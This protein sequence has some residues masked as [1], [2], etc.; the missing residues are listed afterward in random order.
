VDKRC[1]V[2]RT[3]IGLLLL[4]PVFAAD[5]AKPW[6]QQP[7][8]EAGYGLAHGLGAGD[9]NG[10]GRVDILNPYGWWEQPAPPSDAIREVTFATPTRR[11]ASSMVREL[12]GAR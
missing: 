5:P 1:F 2:I 9:V 11:T 10:D 7:V 4:I 8:S 6:T 3:I 12:R